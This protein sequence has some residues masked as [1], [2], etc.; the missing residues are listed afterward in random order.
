[1]A[2]T[3]NFVGDKLI[4]ELPQESKQKLNDDKLTETEAQRVQGSTQEPGA[5]KRAGVATRDPAEFDTK[6][7]GAHGDTK[8]VQDPVL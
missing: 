3:H 7:R 5:N 6:G 2:T 1:M 4:D 8:P